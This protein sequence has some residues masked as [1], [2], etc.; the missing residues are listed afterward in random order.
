MPTRP[1]SHRPHGWRPPELVRAEADKRRPTA[2]RRGYDAEWEALR[3]DVLA[4]RP[5]CEAEKGCSS[6]F[7]LNVHHRVSVRAAP[8]RRLDRTNL[9]VLCHNC[10]SRLTALETGLGR[11]P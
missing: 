11:H 3:K 4:E 2:A 7:R 10:H 6:T 8:E 5:W 9:Q 1:P